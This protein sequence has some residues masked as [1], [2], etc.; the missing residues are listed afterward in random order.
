MCSFWQS[1]AS[2]GVSWNRL[3]AVGRDSRVVGRGVKP[4]LK[5]LTV[6]HYV[7]WAAGPPFFRREHI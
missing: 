3:W 7:N 1:G 6:T 5:L 4:Y 2:D